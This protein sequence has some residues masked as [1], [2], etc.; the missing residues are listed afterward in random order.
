MNSYDVIIAGTGA[1]G[2]FAALHLPP[3]FRV[4]LLTKDDLEN[5]GFLSGPGRHLHALESGGLP[6]LL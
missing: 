5:S 1:A 6:V 3:D 2:L 4:L